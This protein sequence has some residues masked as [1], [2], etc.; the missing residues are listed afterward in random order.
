MAAQ[1][2]LETQDAN[3]AMQVCQAIVQLAGGGAPAPAEAPGQ[4]VY[5]KGGVLKYWKK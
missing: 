4:P 1:Q 2:A 3:L 5:R